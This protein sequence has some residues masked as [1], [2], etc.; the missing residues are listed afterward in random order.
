MK[1]LSCESCGAQTAEGFA[2]CPACM[3]AAGAASADV[4][5]AEH[6]LDIAKV[7]SIAEPEGTATDAIQGLL[8][9]AARLKV[10]F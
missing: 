2:H 9:I 7:V 5:D 6:A 10:G 4:Q 8:N 1:I 3:K